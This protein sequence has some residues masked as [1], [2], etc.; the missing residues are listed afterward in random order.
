MS[1]FRTSSKRRMGVRRLVIF[2]GAAFGASLAILLAISGIQQ[3]A[4][5]AAEAP[6]VLIDNYQFS[7]NSLTVP[8]GATVTWINKD[9]EVHSVE[10]DSTPPTF[11]SGGLDTDD[12]FTFTF[13]NAGTYDYHCTLHPH[14]T[15]KIVVQ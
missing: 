14:M 3:R 4:A 11:K 9:S 12:K 13:T 7:P 1:D 8:A 10:S 5:D 6:V 2:S 15:G